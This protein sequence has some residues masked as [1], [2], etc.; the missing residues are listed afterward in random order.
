MK[1]VALRFRSSLAEVLLGHTTSSAQ[2]VA[3]IS[4]AGLCLAAL[5]HAG[6]EA[7][8][9]QHELDE[10]SDVL[11][12][13]KAATQ[14]KERPTRVPSLSPQQVQALNLTIGHLNTPWSDVFDALEEQARSDVA[15]L[16]IEPDAGRRSVRIEA[17]GRTLQELLRY[18][19]RLGT[20]PRFGS[21]E[22]TK[23]EFNDR[24]PAR[25]VRLTI[26]ASLPP[27]ET[28]RGVQAP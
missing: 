11:A 25:P 4:A 1:R 12:Q 8:L 21:I 17:E 24:D 27:R 7:A 28:D 22:L 20:S 2:R 9:V 16:S 5:V 13:R 26:N 15:L 23:H 3:A 6:W 14:S 18:S 10:V 19:A